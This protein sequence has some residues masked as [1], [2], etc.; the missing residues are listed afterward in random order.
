M[1][2]V[3]LLLALAFFAVKAMFGPRP[4]TSPATANI[5]ETSTP[6][7]TS[8]TTPTSTPTPTTPPTADS[9]CHVVIGDLLLGKKIITTNQVTT[10]SVT[11]EKNPDDTP[12]LFNWRATYGDLNPGLRTSAIQSTYTPPL[13]PINDVIF[14]EVEAKGCNV[15][16]RSAEINIIAPSQ[17]EPSQTP[18]NTAT[19]SVTPSPTFTPTPTIKSS[20]VVESFENYTDASLRDSYFLNTYA[21]NEGTMSLVGGPHNQQGQVALAFEY[22]ILHQQPNHYIGFEKEFPFQDW[23]EYT[24][25]CVWIEWDGSNR[26]VVIQFGENAGRSWKP[27]YPLSILGTGEYCIPITAS[28]LNLASIGYYGIYIEG[29]AGDPSIVY[30][31][32]VHVTTD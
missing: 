25:L 24:K 5:T 19:P 28:G 16:Q 23:S 11:I 2:L 12:L 9:P 26:G 8:T 4:T 1:V 14:L 21:G 7:A 3:I 29:A 10:V 18:T 17:N 22:H 6:T 15:I 32:N 13:D 30:F 27:T 31:D 20:L